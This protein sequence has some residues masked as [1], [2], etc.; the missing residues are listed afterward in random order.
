[1]WFLQR[2][3]RLLLITRRLACFRKWSGIE[4]SWTKVR[5][6]VPIAVHMVIITYLV[7]IQQKQPIGLEI[8]PPSNSERLPVLTQA[9]DGA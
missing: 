1:M 8:H 6:E 5:Y 3:E 2:T 7:L 4:L 9:E